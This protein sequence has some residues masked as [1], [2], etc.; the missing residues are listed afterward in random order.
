MPEAD[1]N[2]DKRPLCRSQQGPSV[3]LQD[4]A[5]R[6]KYAAG[7]RSAE[8]ES[9]VKG[10]SFCGRSVTAKILL[11]TWFQRIS[12]SADKAKAFV[13]CEEMKSAT[14]RRPSR[15]RRRVIL[16][17]S[18]FSRK[19]SRPTRQANQMESHLPVRA[20]DAGRWLSATDSLGLVPFHLSGSQFALE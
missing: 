12:E 3:L 2:E 15:T 16:A 6:Q 1:K 11:R 14:D 18:L 8:G 20:P 17:T 7:R 9:N 4:Y 13:S 5:H 19:I 10:S